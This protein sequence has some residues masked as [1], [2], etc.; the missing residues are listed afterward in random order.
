VRNLESIR[1][2]GLRPGQRHAVHLSP[3]VDTADKVG[4]RRGEH[5]VLGVDAGA[6]H[7]A[8]HVF[9]VSAN[10]VWLVSSVPPVYLR[11]RGRWRD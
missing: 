1:R 5:A 9:T 8:G 2:E 4:A 11:F 6:M 7:R 10:G 3:D